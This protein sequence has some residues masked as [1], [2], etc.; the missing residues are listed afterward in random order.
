MHEGWEFKEETQKY[1]TRWAVCGKSKNGKI[2]TQV[3]KDIAQLDENN[4]IKYLANVPE[5]SALFDSYK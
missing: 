3:G 5:D 4:K 1:E 2:Y